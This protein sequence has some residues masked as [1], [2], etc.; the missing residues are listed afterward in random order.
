[1]PGTGPLRRSSTPVRE[2]AIVDKSRIEAERLRSPR[3]FFVALVSMSFTG[4]VCSCF[5]DGL[6]RQKSLVAGSLL[7]DIGPQEA[8]VVLVNMAQQ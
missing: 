5:S 2:K 3:A 1:M 4:T 8:E 7:R 6:S